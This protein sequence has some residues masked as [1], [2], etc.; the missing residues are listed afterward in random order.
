MATLTR[1]TAAWV[2]L[3]R[4]A[5]RRMVRGF[6]YMRGFVQLKECVCVCFLF[7]S[8]NLGT[9]SSCA[10]HQGDPSF[11]GAAHGPWLPRLE[12]ETMAGGRLQPPSKTAKINAYQVR[13][14]QQPPFLELWC[15]CFSLVSWRNL[16]SPQPFL[17][18][19]L[20]LHVE[21]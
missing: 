13:S 21:L 12:R 2:L 5:R 14:F 3:S 19:S 15:L 10:R 20:R 6:L 17:V 11:Q 9:P 1:P 7:F 8:R 4:G 16:F 18:S